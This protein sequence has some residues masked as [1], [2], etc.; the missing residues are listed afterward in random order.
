MRLLLSLV[1]ALVSL[2]AIAQ[3][4]RCTE[5]GSVCICSEPL[6]ATSYVEDSNDYKNPNDSS[7]K[8]CAQDGVSGG[9]VVRTV[10]DVVASSD[11]TALAALPV[12]H[13]LARFMRAADGHTGTF[14]L[15]ST[16]AV[17]SGVLRIAVRWYQYRTS[18][19]QFKT[20][21]S[22]ENSKSGE[23]ATNTVVDVTDSGNGTHVNWHTY[24]YTSGNGWSPG[25]DCCI[26]GPAPSS[27]NHVLKT[28]VKGKWWRYEMVI[29][30]RASSSFKLVMYG[31]NVTDD[32]AE[33]TL[34]DTSLDA[35]LV[36]QT[37]PA[38]ISRILSNNHRF[39]TCNGWM[40][41]AYFMVAGWTSDTGQRISAASEIEGGGGP[42]PGCGA[43]QTCLPFLLSDLDEAALDDFFAMAE[44][45]RP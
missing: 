26:S 30:G 25:T 24:A 11:A 2:Q 31:K 3:E 15:G 43:G 5:L 37:P 12:G 28:A 22:C 41:L 34:I 32:S 10:D 40:G 4:A 20:E 18:N 33:V 8:E 39:G 19:F 45:G 14:Y 9:A 6:Q 44:N 38:L 29:T 1:F 36:G 42:A 21:G 17:G 7:T 13:S 16:T 23:F 35:Q 27:Q